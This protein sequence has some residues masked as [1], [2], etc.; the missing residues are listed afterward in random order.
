MSQPSWLEFR[1]RAF[2]QWFE[3]EERGLVNGESHRW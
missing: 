3:M 2:G 1:L